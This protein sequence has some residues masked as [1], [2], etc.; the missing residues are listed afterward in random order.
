MRPTR[1]ISFHARISEFLLLTRLRLRRHPANPKQ[2]PE[3]IERASHVVLVTCQ[4]WFLTRYGKASQ[5][6]APL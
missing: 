4:H 6:R 2:T 3:I 1:S 5:H